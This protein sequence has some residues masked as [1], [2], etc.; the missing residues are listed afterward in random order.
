ML[1]ATREG[2]WLLLLCLKDGS[3]H[4]SFMLPKE[5]PYLQVPCWFLPQLR[6]LCPL[7][8]DQN[9]E[10]SLPLRGKCPGNQDPCK[11][12]EARQPPSQLHPG[13]PKWLA[14]STRES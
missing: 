10:G 14:G 7:Q 2:M 13:K 3:Y 12:C 6:P 11:T 5:V 1:A 4:P 9:G 8:R